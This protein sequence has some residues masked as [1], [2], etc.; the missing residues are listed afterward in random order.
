MPLG[1]EKFD[2][3]YCP[4]GALPVA[5]KIY[6]GIYTLMI[7]DGTHRTF[8]IHTKGGKGSLAGRRILSLLRGPDNERDYQPFAFVD[9]R[10]IRVWHKHQDKGLYGSYAEII[11]KLLNGEDVQGYSMEVSR[12]CLVCNR[13]LT[14]P[15]S[16]QLGVGPV[17]R[18]KH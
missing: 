12:R 13:T 5:S 4:A 1:L 17:C 15:L 3:D 8:R 6:N 18:E 7:S 14:D 11:W 16:L 2:A 10:G 9:D